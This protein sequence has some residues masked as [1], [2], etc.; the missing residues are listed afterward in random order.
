ME[1]RNP[2]RERL[3]QGELSLG[4][5]LRQARTV[6][7]AMAMQ[8]CG[9]DWLFIDLEHNSMTLDMAVQISVAANGAGISPL[10]RVPYRQFD[11]AT[12]VLDGG[13][14]GIVMPHVDTVEEAKEVVEKLK[15]PPLGHRSVAGPMAQTGFAAKP[16]AEATA[17][18][19]AAMLLICLVESPTAVK[20]ADKIA[21]VPGIDVLL[22]GT[23]DL[24]MEMGI[25][26]QLSH[27]DVEKA[28]KT[29][30]AACKKHGKWAGMGGIYEPSLM[31]KFLK[32][33]I[34]MVL[35][36]SDLSLLMEVSRQ[37]TGLLRE[38]R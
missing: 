15:Y 30:I 22:F 8:A 4:I 11:M 37:R 19:N 38:A 18:F 36:G 23:S 6:D 27:P 20:N 26:G 10:V 34:S 12:R 2:A 28:Y 16:L 13:A 25:P 21:A 24:T 35:A 17:E 7:I 14:M 29:V 31:R 32:L 1:L 33:G 3:E 5:G 9:F